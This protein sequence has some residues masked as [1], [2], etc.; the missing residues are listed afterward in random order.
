MDWTYGMVSVGSLAGYQISRGQT[1]ASQKE[2]GTTGT[3]ENG[4]IKFPTRSMLVSMANYN[5]AGLYYANNNGA[6]TVAMPGVIL[7]DY[8]LEVAYAGKYTDVKGNDAGIL[9]QLAEVGGD[10]ESVRLALIAGADVDAAVEG[11]LSGALKGVD[12]AP[13]AATIQLPFAGEPADGTYSIIAIAYAEGDAQTISSAAFKYTSQ[14]NVET[15]TAKFIGDYTYTLLFGTEDEPALDEDLVLFQSDTNPNRWKIEHWG[16]DVDFCFT[17][18]GATGELVVDDQETGAT[19]SAG[20]IYVDDLVDFT[21]STQYGQSSYA[22]GV[23]TFAV[24][25]YAGDGSPQYAY[26]NETFTL[27]ANAPAEVAAKAKAAPMF[28]WNTAKVSKAHRVK[29]LKKAALLGAPLR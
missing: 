14:T 13:V 9:A 18:N 3:Y 11:L 5:D 24:I 19:A 4:I 27:T 17:Y 15:W 23:F 28:R 25:Y 29:L 16:Y 7:A 2:A 6:F 8:A 26:G 21:G 12:V 20:M 10:V 1:V 22:S